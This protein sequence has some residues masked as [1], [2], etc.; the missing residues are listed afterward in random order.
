M[1]RTRRTRMAEL[2]SRTGV[3][4]NWSKLRV[5]QTLVCGG[6]IACSQNARQARS[7]GNPQ[8]EV[9]ATKTLL[10]A[11]VA[12]QARLLARARLDVE[13][14]HS[15]SGGVIRAVVVVDDGSPSFER[16]HGEGVALEIVARVAQ[17]F[18]RVPIVGEV[19]VAAVHAQ[20]GVVL[21]VGGLVPDLAGRPALFAFADDV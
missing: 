1:S 4:F 16:A 5:A 10:G 11:V 20:D 14:P 18:V 17:D 2:I 3:E 6:S 13:R 19:R 15:P 7:N 12:G 21:V 8:T 9:C